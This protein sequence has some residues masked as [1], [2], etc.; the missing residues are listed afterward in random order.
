MT[1]SLEAMSDKLK[2]LTSASQFTESVGTR[3]RASWG[4]DD[5]VQLELVSAT[6]FAKGSRVGGT[7]EPFSLVFRAQD[8]R[9]H[10]AQGIYLLEHE[11]HDAIHVFLVPIGPDEKG[12]R[13]E[14][15]FN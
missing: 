12:V 8:P 2:A 13:M 14:A 15:V 6:P 5:S 11:K 1:E 9:Q 7:R 4:T 3:F 10:L